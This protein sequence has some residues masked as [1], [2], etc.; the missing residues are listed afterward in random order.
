MRCIS[1]L[2]PR[3]YEPTTYV[4]NSMKKQ[5]RFIQEAIM[6]F[7]RPD[8]ILLF[9]TRH[10]EEVNYGELAERIERVKLVRIP[11]GKKERE[12]WEIFEIISSEV[13]QGERIVFDITHGFRSLPFISFLSIAYLREVK[14]VKIEKVL[15][16]AFEAKKEN[17]TPIFDLTNFTKILDWMNA[18]RAFTRF[19]NA[20][21]LCR[22]MKE[23]HKSAYVENYEF[24]P[25]KISSWANKI[26]EFSLAVHL[27]RPKEALETATKIV[28]N[29]DEAS[30]E[31]KV[32]IP[33]AAQILDRI[34]ELNNF[35]G[36]WKL[37]WQ[38]LERQL[39]LIRYQMN[40]GL[41]IQAVELAREWFVSYMILRLEYRI[42]EW[43]KR[44]VRQTVELTISGLLKKR[45]G[46]S[47]TP[48]ELMDRLESFEDC[49]RMVEIW[50]ELSQLRNDLAHCG[51]NPNPRNIRKISKDSEKLVRE[52]FDLL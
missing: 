25:R 18:V 16:C 47:Y 15:Y 40:N 9:S 49:D 34:R 41:L 31:I 10:A 13:E 30:K 17:E 7:F 27:S 24:K 45:L 6:E 44:D 46:E 50:S 21:E 37:S 29:F 2:G 52:L 48:T 8:E 51:M 26:E 14:G 42:S 32:L 23:I 11:D 36:E 3:K 19:A 20:T 33:P 22:L 38:S 12:L 1:F 35:S 39:N 28:Q 4:Y 5:T 43:L